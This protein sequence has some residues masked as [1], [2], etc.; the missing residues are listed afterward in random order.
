[1]PDDLEPFDFAVT[2][3]VTLFLLCAGF[4]LSAV[5]LHVIGGI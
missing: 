1:M 4:L 5:A 2:L 3:V